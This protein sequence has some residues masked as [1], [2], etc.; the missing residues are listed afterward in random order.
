[1]SH[2]STQTYSNVPIISHNFVLTAPCYR[3]SRRFWMK[4]FLNLNLNKIIFLW[5]VYLCKYSSIQLFF[6]TR[7]A[8]FSG[9]IFAPFKALFSE[10]IFSEKYKLTARV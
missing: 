10:R 3:G 8:R 2:F 7:L 5:T 4:L 6:N 9:G 1:M